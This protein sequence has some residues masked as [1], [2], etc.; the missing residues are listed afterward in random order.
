[1]GGLDEIREF[2]AACGRRAGGDE[3]VCHLQIIA[4]ALELSVYTEAGQLLDSLMM[5]AGRLPMRAEEMPP[6]IGTF[7]RL[8]QD[9]PGGSFAAG[10]I[11]NR[12]T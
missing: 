3:V 7:V 12:V 1:M 5:P 10:G 9:R 2:V 4:N 11:Q 6:L 8:V